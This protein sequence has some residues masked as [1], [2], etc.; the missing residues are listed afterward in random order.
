MKTKNIFIEETINFLVIFILMCVFLIAP[1][2][3]MLWGLSKNNY[4]IMGG[5]LLYIILLCIVMK[6][7][8]RKENAIKDIKEAK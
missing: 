7:L 6:T 2:M 5:Y 3:G 4:W 8:S 1:T